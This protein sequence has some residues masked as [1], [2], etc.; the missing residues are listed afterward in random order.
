MLITNGI[1]MFEIETNFMGQKG[2]IHPTLIWDHEM[3][4]LVDTGYPGQKENFLKEFKKAGVPFE[5]LKKVIITHH[6]ID[7][8][9]SLP[10]IVSESP[11]KIEVIANG[12]EKPHIQGEK[13]LLKLT[14]EA[15]AQIDA[16]PEQ[17]R[18]AIKPILLHPPKEK[19]DTIVMDSEELPFCGGIIVIDTPGHTPGHISL[20]HNQSKTLIA[21]DA[22]IV[23]DGQLLG[24]DP[25]HTIDMELAKKSL[26]KFSQYDIQT[27]ICYHGGL[28]NDNVNER[29]VQLAN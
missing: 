7:H 4:V 9:G 24:P 5:N 17:W 14:E 1:E 19:V 29:I 6:D 16:W 25:E 28:F 21:A 20:Y 3:A 27:V 11:Q 13:G 18:N 12:F 2:H 8:I 15:L 10:S 23:K 22:L 26:S